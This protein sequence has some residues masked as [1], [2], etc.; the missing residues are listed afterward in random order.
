MATPKRLLI[1][2]LIPIEVAVALLIAGLPTHLLSPDAQ[3]YAASQGSAALSTTPTST[4]SQPVV[5][6]PSPES[7][8]APTT[9]SPS[10][11]LTPEESV[12]T[13]TPVASPTAMDTPTPTPSSTPPSAMPPATVAASPTAT[14]LPSF[15]V[16]NTGGDGANLCRSPSTKSTRLR[17]IPEGTV[18]VATGPSVSAEGAVWYPVRDP[19][20][21]SGWVQGRYLAARPPA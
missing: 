7:A 16:A 1:G 3:T 12:P 14:P 11:T 20:G 5:I 17:T 10:A 15:V 21:T 9:P 4:P 8:L 6:A 18:V 19:H 13:S 2:V